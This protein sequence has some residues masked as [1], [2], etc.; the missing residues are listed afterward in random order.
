MRNHG[1]MTVGGSVHEAFF[2]MYQ[3]I[4][5]CKVQ[6]LCNIPNTGDDARDLVGMSIVPDQI[7]ADTYKIVRACVRSCV[8]VGD[9][10]SARA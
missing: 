5:A 1:C 2:L 10:L 3:L 8:C 4:E 9:A 6:L 7:V